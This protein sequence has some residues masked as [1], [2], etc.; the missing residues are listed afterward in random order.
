M[1]YFSIILFLLSL[2]NPVFGQIDFTTF[3]E[4]KCR[5][6]GPAGMSGRITAIDVDLSDE[7]KIFIGSASGGVWK[8]ENGGTTWTPI[9]DDQSNLAIGS[10]KINQKN[11][12]EIWVGTGEGN[13]R[14]SI[15]TGNGIYKSLDGGKTWKNMGLSDTKVIHRIVVDA[16]D[17]N[18]VY[19]AAMGSPWGDSEDRGVFKTKD[20]GK[21]WKR[22]LYVNAATGAAEM[23][24]D[25]KNPNK[26]I[27]GM[28]EHRR[29][30]WFFKSG[31]KGSGIYITY[32][33]GETWKQITEKDGLP[34]GELG[35][36]GLSFAPSN[37]D[38][39]YALVEAKENGLYKS[40]DGGEHWSLVSTKDIGD[41]PFYYSEIY[42]DPENAN[43]IYNLY[44]YVSKSED[45][46]KSFKNIANYSNGVHPDH[47]AFWIHPANSRYIIEGN[48]GG[49]NISK[50]AGKTWQFSGN[51][52]VGQFYHIQ[53]DTAFPY[54]VYGGMQ[55][56][57]SWVGPSSVLK[58]GGIRNYDFQELYFGDG[59]DVV[60]LVHDPRYGFAMSQGGN[61]GFYDRL[62]GRTQF[63][64]PVTQDTSISYRFNWNAGIAKDPFSDCGVYFGSQFL[65][66]SD[67]CGRSWI[68][69]SPDLTTNDAEKQ[70]ADKSGG[71]T[72]DATFAENYTTI[73]CIEPSR[74]DKDV[75]WVGTDDGNVQKT[76]DGG[77][78][79]ENVASRL[80]NLPE[81]SWIPQI[82][83]SPYNK[84]E[85]W[86]V[87]NNYRRNDYKPYAYHTDNGGK[88]FK[89]IADETSIGGFVL[90]IVQDHKEPN[91]IF[92]GTDAGL[93]ISVDKAKTWNHVDKILPNV[94]ISDLKIHPIED[95]L[96]IGTFGRSIWIMDDINPLREL[97]REGLTLL[98][99][100]YHLFDQAVGYDVSF[101][102]YDGIRFSAQ[103]EFIG[104]NKE[105]SSANLNFWKKPT[106]EDTTSINE[107]N[108]K[109]TI[110]IFDKNND[111]IRTFKSKVEDGFNRILWN[112]RRDGSSPF[113]RNKKKDSENLP[114]GEKVEPGLYKAIVSFGK[115]KDSTEIIVK[116]D[117]RTS[118]SNAVKQEL[119]VLNDSIRNI[120]DMSVAEFEKLIE[121]K[122]YVLAVDRFVELLPK[123][124]KSKYEAIQKEMKDTIEALIVLYVA[125][126]NQKGIQRN[127][128]LLSDILNQANYYARSLW[129][130]P[131]NNAIYALKN[132]SAYSAAING[133]V[134]RFLSGQWLEY[135]DNIRNSQLYW[136][137]S[138][139]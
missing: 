107:E 54:N 109:L 8:T 47:H 19:A 46:G 125:P 92:L 48:D 101:R 30:P 81:G 133:K 65:H 91:L 111:N 123:D 57:G 4:L 124:R 113:D 76:G 55:D 51:I 87:A 62:T 60:P 34:K 126:E 117:P 68:T 130:S 70:K 6:I 119:A 29:Q 16:L 35:R 135:L 25:P 58:Q 67:D 45:G 13:P 127:P 110:K 75:I 120:S 23:V 26:L 71:L 85:M 31:G 84:D 18:T 7:T 32:D 139:K 15:N 89:R 56:N 3:K 24:V 17:G 28:W 112:L 93:Y 53:Y 69:L 52:P 50:D 64:K 94:Q 104:Q 10:I 80:R 5:N 122:N 90:S 115:F 103:G 20:G 138:S 134:R 121:A 49:L 33:G 73:L 102:S 14:N 97:A 40:I 9:F 83:Q 42:V 43:T 59:F 66:Y 108:R 27:V 116:M 39:V 37:P 79:W 88:T 131:G 74:F 98:E 2:F 99:K 132:T 114:S 11:P 118:E 63:S 78:T 44:T 41:R 86:I 21:T 105:Y 136:F 77:K 96:I 1:R 12:S 61:L 106:L 36:I 128:K 72:L 22:I 129:Q 100:D 95:D 137:D 38:I 82:V